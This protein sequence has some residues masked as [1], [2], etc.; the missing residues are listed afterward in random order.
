MSVRLRIPVL[1]GFIVLLLHTGCGYRYYTGP[2]YPA[3][4]SERVLNLQVSDDGTVT[5]IDGRL[6]IG[7]RPMTDEALNRHFHRHSHSGL[8]S[9]NPYTFGDWEDPELQQVPSRFTV[10]LVSV[11]NY[12]Y[13]KMRLDPSRVVIVAD[14]GRRY[15]P[16]TLRQLEDY[17]LRYAIAYAG[18]KYARH[19]E[20]MSILRNSMYRDDFIFSGQEAEGY[21]VFPVLHH[22]VQRI[23]V[24][25][26]DVAL[27]FDVWDEPIE[28]VDVEYVFEREIGR[29]H[30]NEQVAAHSKP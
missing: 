2:L 29:V 16:L 20:R 28:K 26:R 9:T 14:N 18:N 10:F 17:Y 21:I 11:K 7:I 15:T 24:I 19:R 13:P 6:E 12:M 27:R 4:E 22:D 25:L 1:T 3:P 5:F 30:V 23:T 8:E